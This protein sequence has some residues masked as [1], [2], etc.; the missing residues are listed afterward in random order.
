MNQNFEMLVQNELY[1]NPTPRIPVCLCLDTSG[2]MDGQPLQELMNGINMFYEAIREDEIALNSAEIS[3]V[4]FGDGVRC[5]EDFSSLDLKGET[6]NLIAGGY[7]PMGEGVNL[8]LDILEKR[9]KDYQNA[10]VD[11]YQPWLVLMTDGTPVNSSQYEMDKA[12]KRT[13]NLAL[14]KKLTIFPI[15]I[16]EEADMDMLQQFSPTRKPLKLQGLKFQE[17]FK[18][19]SKSISITSSSGLGEKIKLDADGLQDWINL[20]V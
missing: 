18:W 17:F 11:Y 20:E 12:I 9:K 8:A 16:G 2:S 6:P 19:L 14:E 15:G 13:S 10:G 7:T 1:D 3:I 4:T 5:Y